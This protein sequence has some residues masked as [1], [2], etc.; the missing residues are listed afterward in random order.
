[1]AD[2]DPFLAKL[3]G[4]APQGGQPT[5]APQDDPFLAK[6]R[7][8]K[9]ETTVSAAPWG[10]P[11]TKARVRTS[12]DILGD[13]G[14]APPLVPYGEFATE[15]LPESPQERLR[16]RTPYM[17]AF[18][19]RHAHEGVRVPEEPPS[20][21]EVL[22]RALGEFL[23]RTGQHYVR[24]V[25][26]PL[27]DLGQRVYKTFAHPE[28]IDREFMAMPR[29]KREEY[30][31]STF[32]RT[33]DFVTSR[34]AQAGMAAHPA[35]GLPMA[36]GAVAKEEVE[37][38]GADAPFIARAVERTANA[39]WEGL[40]AVGEGVT[41]LT[42]SE[43][44]G[45][46][47][48]LGLLKGAHET[49]GLGKAAARGI[50]EAYRGP[51]VLG[52]PE[53]PALPTSA[54]AEFGTT[55][56]PELPAAWR[57]A[58]PPEPMEGAG[59]LP[60]PP[61]R[62]RAPLEEA[63][64]RPDI[65]LESRLVQTLGLTP[66][67]ARAVVAQAE[68]EMAQRAESRGGTVRRTDQS[69][70]MEE[71]TGVQLEVRD[72]YR[73]PFETVTPPEAAEAPRPAPALGTSPEA[74]RARET[75]AA[76]AKSAQQESLE[77]ERAALRE[78]GIEPKGPG[79]Y[80]NEPPEVP[81]PLPPVDMSPEAVRAREEAA[82]I[83][84]ST[85]RESAEQERQRLREAGIEPARTPEPEAAEGPK[86]IPPESPE[87]GAQ[88]QRIERAVAIR[89][90]MANV[91][92]KD[93]G[94]YVTDTTL[95]A[96]L[97][98]TEP[99][100]PAA[101][102]AWLAAFERMSPRQ[103]KALAARIK[104]RVP[105]VTAEEIRSA[106][107][108]GPKPKVVDVAPEAA[109]GAAP[110]PKPKVDPYAGV[111]REPGKVNRPTEPPPKVYKQDTTPK[112]PPNAT[113]ERGL[114]GPAPK[115]F[116]RQASPAAQTD[117]VPPPGE[118]TV[119]TAGERAIA[120]QGG[121][122]AVAAAT[123]REV[124]SEP[125]GAKA[126]VPPEGVPAA[127]AKAAEGKLAEVVNGEGTAPKPAAPTH[128]V[129]GRD[130][131]G[132]EVRSVLVDTPEKL[133]S[134]Q[135]ALTDAGLTVEV[136]PATAENLNAVLEQRGEP[137]Q[138]AAERPVINLE[139]A[140]SERIIERARKYVAEL[141]EIGDAFRDGMDFPADYLNAK[142][143]IF[144]RIDAEG[145]EMR[146]AVQGLFQEMIDKLPPEPAAAGKVIKGK[147]G[148]PQK[149]AVVE[150]EVPASPPSA[151]GTSTA[152]DGTFYG[153]KGELRMRTEDVQV[154]PARFQH[155][156]ADARGRTARLK[157]TKTWEEPTE[158]I[159]VWRD[160]AD[161]KIYVVNGFQ[162]TGLATDLKVPDL[163][164]K[165]IEAKDAA[166]ARIEGA[167][168]NLRSG[169]ASPADVARFFRE[170]KLD[171]Q[172]ADSY[173]E[174]IGATE[175]APGV[176]E[177]R[178][179]AA[180]PD[181][182][183]NEYLQNKLKEPRAVAFGNAIRDQALTT[184]QALQ[185]LADGAKTPVDELWSLARS[186]K[187]AG[188]ESKA[189][190]AG[191]FGVIEAPKSLRALEGRIRSGML[192]ALAEDK[193][194]I[195]GALKN[196]DVLAKKGV[197]NVDVEA[198]RELV[199]TS[200]TLH[201]QAQAWLKSDARTPLDD[202]VSEAAK[203]VDQMRMSEDAAVTDLTKQ[204]KDWLMSDPTVNAKVKSFG[205]Q[206]ATPLFGG[207]PA[208]KPAVAE[209]RDV[210]TGTP[211]AA[212]P[213]STEVPPPA[214][215]PSATEPPK[216]KKRFG[217]R[218]EKGAVQ[219]PTAK[220]LKEGFEK[221]ELAGAKTWQSVSH[222]VADA[223]SKI[224]DKI[225]GWKGL[226]QWGVHEALNI[227][228]TEKLFQATERHSGRITEG[229]R[230]AELAARGL[231]AV[232]RRLSPRASNLVGDYMDGSRPDLPPEAMP[233]Q[234]Q[235]DAAVGDMHRTRLEMLARKL[236][237]PDVFK[238]YPRF[239]S[240]IY[241]VFARE[242][243]QPFGASTLAKLSEELYRQDAHG[244]IVNV[245]EEVAKI[246]AE[247]HNPKVV[248]GTARQ[249]LLKFETP[250][251]R[252]AFM[253]DLQA[254]DSAQ[255]GRLGRKETLVSER[256]EPLPADVRQS[257]GEIAAPGDRFAMTLAKAKA[258]IATYDL[259]AEMQT[260]GKGQPGGDWIMPEGAGP[261]LKDYTQ[262][263]GPSWG[264][265]NGKWLRDDIHDYAKPL[266]E[267]Q[268]TN[269]VA[270]AIRAA[271]G[272]WKFD[273]T[274]GSWPTVVRNWLSSHWMSTEAGVNYANPSNWGYWQDSIKALL[275]KDEALRKW[276]VEHKIVDNDVYSKEFK[277]RVE[278]AIH[279]S[280][281]PIPAI[282]EALKAAREEGLSRKAKQ[283]MVRRGAEAVGET[284]VNP[285]NLI[286]GYQR[287]KRAAGAVYAF[288][289]NTR[290][291]AAALKL[292]EQGLEMPELL[293][294]L[295]RTTENYGRQGG[296]QTT[297]QSI[298]IIGPFA[299]FTWERY[300]IAKN[301]LVDHPIRL[302]ETLIYSYVVKKMLESAFG[303]DVTPQEK[304]AADTEYGWQTAVLNP[305]E[306]GRPRTWD[307]R[308]LFPFGQAMAGPELHRQV[309][310]EGRAVANYAARVLGGGLAPGV[311]PLMAMTT[312][313]DSR[314]KPVADPF[315]RHRFGAAAPF[316]EAWREFIAPPLVGRHADEM[317][318]ARH[319][320]PVST[321]Q[322]AK[323]VEDVILGYL[324]GVSLGY[325]DYD[326][327]K[328]N[329][330][331]ML[332]GRQAEVTGAMSKRLK[333][334]EEYRPLEQEALEMV[335]P[336]SD[337]AKGLQERY[338]ALTEAERSRRKKQETVPS[339]R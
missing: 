45:I 174:S 87:A 75:A 214:E 302:A 61:P 286:P 86:L 339:G 15:D 124:V 17:G 193:R 165:F 19:E 261:M 290:R 322:P 73:S 212:P 162:R 192:E 105:D 248:T 108:T 216:A 200:K 291:L 238:E 74:V 221:L 111:G 109:A 9:A 78:A 204:A 81:K 46:L 276:A 272:Q 239:L 292:R 42:K 119:P 33:L 12:A 180:L 310:E 156:E 176:A 199:E 326:V 48:E 91:V 331:T 97:E 284:A 237:S 157:K 58:P 101:A 66:E 30:A 11:A 4:R 186:V 258:K 263:H 29:E 137:A 152:P 25:E 168:E 324:A 99:Q 118:G 85:M 227:E 189:P 325:M 98:T 110:P 262:V 7:A 213:T 32:P 103:V 209:T 158:P 312:G 104:E 278:R 274:V 14:A 138:P 309:G 316:F 51:D 155:K 181:A 24:G 285:A 83:E 151:S 329:L 327:A 334:G 79:I 135:K 38:A 10:G 275:G 314:G 65:T 233:Y 145:P 273:R 68:A 332:Q 225:P 333:A 321:R 62:F 56:R 210:V 281:N 279:G 164:I 236:I 245:P 82:T 115:R 223:V 166:T 280:E 293:R 298:P 150:G 67:Q 169:H 190:T 283:A 231:D 37:G 64:A 198:G 121:P 317:A 215:R 3:R 206:Q 294:Q 303:R 252:E 270:D 277:G 112:P 336:Q 84:R 246:V 69:Y 203:A 27:A 171:P 220:E 139:K 205:R 20:Y 311:E 43:A 149:A 179:L 313:K 125:S 305:D 100:S 93:A 219:L 323:T 2:D 89:D 31:A 131:T 96:A 36:A 300:R 47:S 35:A 282:W 287:F 120:E 59:T 188:S 160:P 23:G 159:S 130:A 18:L 328:R 1:M 254:W 224:A 201:G 234:K 16:A 187:L 6:L 90:E 226:R 191:L 8:P 53:A 40:H 50:R 146:A 123:G 148:Q 144:K 172:A 307:S 127:Q 266:M 253:Q 289:N 60:P 217:K 44:L 299:R 49:G 117:L 271:Y 175:R 235:I 106:L 251:A 196:A 267:G 243:R 269:P 320:V 163:P 202:M 132:A 114:P 26:A 195:G 142:R 21:P 126:I 319:G 197:A 88:T 207:E 129:I 301:N 102:Q 318:A 143:A 71:P 13:A 306:K 330:E 240:R 259:L 335:G 63:P 268:V 136:K 222:P 170:Q 308:N 92:R 140:A 232:T 134:A 54:V 95:R 39:P 55:A 247:P 295:D 22:D 297:L 255:K 113:A 304:K 116:G 147:F 256:F 229:Q 241:R 218:G 184:D 242:G 28:E 185:L 260:I 228:P 141:E 194:Q 167:K 208:P 183:W 177:G 153:P 72:R 264:E 80:A 94:K 133:A 52:G 257:L 265:L 230:E 182:A 250:E 154:D 315:T 244:V 122:E 34:L 107:S 249:S 296:L 77:R 338:D 76:E 161:G 211:E 41:S 337:L 178:A 70:G 288:E 128:V 57:P 5:A 173:L